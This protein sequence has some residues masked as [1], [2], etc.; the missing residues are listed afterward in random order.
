MWKQCFALDPSH[1]KYFVRSVDCF[2]ANIINKVMK[3]LRK[4]NQYRNIKF[5]NTQMKFNQI[6]PRPGVK[7][8]IENFVE[9]STFVMHYGSLLL[10]IYMRQLSKTMDISTLVFLCKAHKHALSQFAKIHN[11][12]CRSVEADA[13]VET[14]C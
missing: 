6:Q 9:K 13:F 10:N 14:L 1:L 12:P 11:H 7:D 4:F 8:L 2:D 5:L 3:H